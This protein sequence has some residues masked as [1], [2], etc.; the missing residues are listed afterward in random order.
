MLNRNIKKLLLTNC[1]KGK[2]G[3]LFPWV[4][5]LDC[6]VKKRKSF[7]SRSHDLLSSVKRNCINTLKYNS[8]NSSE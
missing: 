6:L 5:W 1:K 7:F 8:L 2:F 4:V 3:H